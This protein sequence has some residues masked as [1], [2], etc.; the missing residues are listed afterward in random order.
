MS[1][2]AGMPGPIAVR[3]CGVQRAAVYQRR[4]PERTAAYQMVGQNLETWLAQRRSVGVVQAPA[5]QCPTMD[6]DW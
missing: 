6:A 2:S 4:R 1:I 3:S 5:K